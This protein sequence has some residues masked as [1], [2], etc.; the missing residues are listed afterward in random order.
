MSSN[1]STPIG[2]LSVGN[3]TILLSTRQRILENFVVHSLEDANQ[4]PSSTEISGPF[5][6]VILG[7]TSNV[8]QIKAQLVGSV[9]ISHQLKF[10]CLE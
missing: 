8:A 10:S 6:L 5:D 4:I 3:E 7:H 9:Q 2:V 1:P